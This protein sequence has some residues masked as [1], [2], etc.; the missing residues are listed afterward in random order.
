MVIFFLSAYLNHFPRLTKS[1]LVIWNASRKPNKLKRWKKKKWQLMKT[2]CVCIPIMVKAWSW[3]LY[4][5][6]AHNLSFFRHFR[7]RCQKHRKKKD[8]VILMAYKKKQFACAQ[9]YSDIHICVI[10]NS[11]LISFTTKCNKHRNHS[12]LWMFLMYF[13]FLFFLTLSRRSIF[14]L[15]KKIAKFGANDMQQQQ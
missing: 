2:I 12:A 6:H 4:H 8:Q 1:L 9:N 14:A 3:S 11:I 10:C 13:F 7:R 15:P 5:A